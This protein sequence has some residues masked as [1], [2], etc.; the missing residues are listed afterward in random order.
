VLARSLGLFASCYLVYHVEST[1]I[2]V[3]HPNIPPSSTC[4]QLISPSLQLS[5]KQ[6]RPPEVQSSQ[7]YLAG[8]HCRINRSSA[9]SQSIIH[10]A[11]LV[12]AP[13]PLTPSTAVR[14]MMAVPA[15][16]TNGTREWIF[17]LRLQVHATSNPL[18]YHEIKRASFRHPTDWS[19]PKPSTPIRRVE[20]KPVHFVR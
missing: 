5:G 3:H 1:P 13:C 2:I 4:F 20:E 8:I 12:A 19:K 7:Q 15:Q 14:C 18:T 9:H 16:G 6:P 11:A 17:V 10:S